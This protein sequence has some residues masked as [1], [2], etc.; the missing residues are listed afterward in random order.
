[1]PERPHD[2][3]RVSDETL[4][5]FEADLPRPEARGGAAKTGQRTGLLLLAGMATCIAVGTAY[6]VVSVL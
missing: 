6:V 3:L 2:P 4:R 5:T 1:M